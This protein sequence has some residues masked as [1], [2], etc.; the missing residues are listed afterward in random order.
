MKKY[1]LFT[2]TLLII[3]TLISVENV[4]IAYADYPSEDVTAT[5]ISE[6][7]SDPDKLLDNANIPVLCAI[8]GVA[9]IIGNYKTR[10]NS[11]SYDE[12]YNEISYNRFDEESTEDILE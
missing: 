7:K 4:T 10:K 3:F 5:E 11:Y 2:T 8:I 9:L 6:Y 12:T 1:L